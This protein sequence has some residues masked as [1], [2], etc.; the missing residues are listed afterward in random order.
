M[1]T[2]TYFSPEQA[3]GAHPRPP[4]RPLLARHRDVRDGRRPAAV[5]GRQPGG[6]RLQAGARGAAAPLRELDPDVPVGLR[7][8]R[9]PS[10][11]PRTPPPR[12]PSAD[13]L[14]ARPAP[15]PRRP[16]A[17]G[18]SPR[19]RPRRHGGRRRGG[20]GRD[21]RTR[22]C[23]RPSATH[24][25]R[26]RIARR[27]GRARPAPARRRRRARRLRRAAPAPGWYVLGVVLAL[28]VLGHR[29][30]SALQRAER[31]QRHGRR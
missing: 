1:G 7:G 20:R 11:W 15:L 5:H 3:Q 9:R 13:D 19:P 4:Q 16:A 31:R 8:H 30:L 29:R 21:G 24:A 17:S 23:R 10:C 6:H 28:L 27:A 22:R 14:R 26:D 25:G 2:A 18:R 12:Y